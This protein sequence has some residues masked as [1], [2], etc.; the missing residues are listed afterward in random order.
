MDVTYSLKQ[1]LVSQY[2]SPSGLLAVL[3]MMLLWKREWAQDIASRIN[4][5]LLTRRLSQGRTTD[6]TAAVQLAATLFVVDEIAGSWSVLTALNGL[7]V[8]EV[9]EV[10]ALADGVTLL[11]LASDLKHPSATDAARGVNAA[12]VRGLGQGIVFDDH[13]LWTDIGQACHTLAMKSF[14]VSAAVL[15][16][17]RRLFQI[18]VPT[19]LW[20]LQRLRPSPWRDETYDSSLR[21]LLDTPPTS[22]AG[23]L[24]G[25]AAG[26][27]AGRLFEVSVENLRNAIQRAPY[28]P[29]ANLCEVA[30]KSPALNMLLRPLRNDLV[31][32]TEERKAWGNWHAERISRSLVRQTWPFPAAV[33]DG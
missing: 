24:T 23:I 9:I 26:A 30:E 20:G 27:V 17:A 16:P 33:G 5:G 21:R 11:N 10:I 29:I 4:Y 12:I 19:L 22:P 31:L 2:T 32:R 14:E 25:L 8:R 6:L 28:R 1:G 15:Q 18:D 3:R 7:D 13:A